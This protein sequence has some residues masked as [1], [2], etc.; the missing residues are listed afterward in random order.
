MNSKREFYQRRKR[1]MNR[2]FEV[3]Y[4]TFPKEEHTQ[5]I[6]AKDWG[7]AYALIKCKFVED[8]G[9]LRNIMLLGA[10]AI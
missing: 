5:L 1:D 7:E 6:W 2:L 3:I 9:D 4:K 8:G 10:R